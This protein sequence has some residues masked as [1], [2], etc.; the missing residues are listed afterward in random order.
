[1]PAAPEIV[2]RLHALRNRIRASLEPI[3]RTRGREHDRAYYDPAVALEW[4]ERWSA[5]ATELRASDPEF[6]N[7]P[8]RPT[9]VP[10]KGSDHEGRG[11]ILRAAV[12]RLH[13]DIEDVW[14]VLNHPSYQTT[15]FT[16]DREGIFA[17][18]QVF[19]AMLAIVSIIRN[20]KK[21]VAVIDG[22]VSEKTL[23]LLTAKGAAVAAEILTGAKSSTPVFKQHAQAFVTQ[24]KSLSVRTGGQFHDRF[25]IIDDA[26][27]Y[28]FG[29][30]LKD[31]ARHTFMFSRIEE[32][33]IVAQLKRDYSAAWTSATVVI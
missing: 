3:Q 2:R 18:G 28:H 19:D 6:V 15:Q 11:L 10:T 30:S 29:A 5:I 24:Y 12:V 13:D 26:D 4:F 23:D 9:P 21:K 8:R 33:G 25:V 20:A 1:M 17:A 22:Y 32:P 31:A 14:D 27:H 7:I 16:L